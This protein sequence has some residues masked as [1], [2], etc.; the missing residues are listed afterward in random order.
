MKFNL[1]LKILVHSYEYNVPKR[2]LKEGLV[3][4]KNQLIYELR[5]PE[6]IEPGRNI[7]SFSYCTVWAVTNKI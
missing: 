3:R 1:F 2:I 7:Q 5:T 6:H 4:M